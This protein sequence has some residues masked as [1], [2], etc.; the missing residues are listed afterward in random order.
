MKTDCIRT[1]T[2]LSAVWL[3]TGAVCSE[4]VE[5]TDQMIDE[6]RSTVER[7]LPALKLRLKKDIV[8]AQNSLRAMKAA[9]IDTKQADN[10]RA[11]GARLFFRSKEVK[12]AAIQVSNRQLDHLKAIQK[13]KAP[14]VPFLRRPLSTGKIG[15][16][17]NPV[18]IIQQIVDE[19]NM[20][21]RIGVGNQNGGFTLN[22]DIWLQGIPT[23]DLAD[24]KAFEEDRVY[25]VVGNRQYDTALGATKT[26]MHVEVF[27][28]AKHE[29]FFAPLE[30]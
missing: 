6:Y 12:E 18:F 16:F 25:R 17:E 4:D 22:E 5:I 13:G 27:D 1:A 8:E 24:G 20:L 21:V 2:I 26:V 11:K 7:Q 19:D 14:Y 3:W 29:K 28:A 9:G 30:K 10:I 23:T 15:R